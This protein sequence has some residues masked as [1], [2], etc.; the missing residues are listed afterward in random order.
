MPTAEEAQLFEELMTHKDEVFRICLGFSRNASDAE[1]LAQDVYLAAFRNVG[2]LHSPYA[3]KEWLLRV[4]RNTC[5]DHQKKRR[6]ARLFRERAQAPES[7]PAPEAPSD[8][9]EANEQLRAL[10]RAVSQLPKKLREAFVLREYGELSYQDVARTLGIKEGTVM[11]RL[12]RARAA[13]A[14]SVKEDIDGQKTE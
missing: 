6:I 8:R 11:S 2:N 12:S 10:K 9:A 14:D 7:G 1:D 13:V 5:L 3:A 4:T